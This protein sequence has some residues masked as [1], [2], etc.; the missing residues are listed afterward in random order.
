MSLGQ[1]FVELLQEL[2]LEEDGFGSLMTWRHIDRVSDPATG[3]VVE[4][5]TEQSFVGAVTRPVDLKPYFDAAN[6]VRMTSGVVIPVGQ[7]VSEPKQLDQ[8][9]VQSG[10]WLRVLD[11]SKL[12]GPGNTG[13]P[14]TIGYLVGLGS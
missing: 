12:M 2:V 11:V 14:V 6:L 5:P 3:D 1:E 7:L 10:V 8:V 9:E 4:T 13:A